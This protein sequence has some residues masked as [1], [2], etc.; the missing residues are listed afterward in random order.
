[1]GGTMLTVDR[2]VDAPPAAVWDLLV[3]L[4]AWPK[5]G[6]TV[7]GARL[8]EPHTE[9]ALGATGVVQTSLLVPVPFVVTDFEP[10]RRWAWEVAGIPA[11]RHWVE[12]IGDG[13]RVGM[14]VPWWAAPY[15]TVCATA[16]RRIDAMLTGAR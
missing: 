10:G 4:D 2:A 5:W 9:L 8:D 6:P 16:L 13:A 14:A 11:T 1:M 7:R 12:P 15:L 3:D